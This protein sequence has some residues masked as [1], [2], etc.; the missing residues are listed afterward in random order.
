MKITLTCI[1]QAE[2][3]PDTDSPLLALRSDRQHDRTL[4]PDEL[5]G[6]ERRYK[7]EWRQVRIMGWGS[8]AGGN[9]NK[10]TPI[11]YSAEIDLDTPVVCQCCKETVPMQYMSDGFL[12]PLCAELPIELREQ[13][14]QDES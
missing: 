3:N 1:W 14:A 5:K 10:P 4:W 6:L 13:M 9:S 7:P 11:V 12:C 2:Q 8:E